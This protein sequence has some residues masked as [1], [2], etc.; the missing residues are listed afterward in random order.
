VAAAVLL[1]A[2]P[3]LGGQGEE[4]GASP[5]LPLSTGGAGAGERDLQEPLLGESDP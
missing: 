5:Q 4:G 2:A 3:R 1:C